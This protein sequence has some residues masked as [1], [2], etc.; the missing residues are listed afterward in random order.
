M[1][2][3]ERNTLADYRRYLERHVEDMA[4]LPLEHMSDHLRRANDIISLIDSFVERDSPDPSV[5]IQASA[6]L[7]AEIIDHLQWFHTM[8]NYA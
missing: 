4:R 6:D 8:E 7:N 2:T 3:T 5:I 1:T